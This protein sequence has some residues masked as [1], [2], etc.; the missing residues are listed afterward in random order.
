MRRGI[1]V[2]GFMGCFI[3]LTLFAGMP[4][5]EAQKLVPQVKLILDRLP[6]EKQKRLVDFESAVSTYLA[7]ADWTGDMSWELPLNL[8]VYLQDVSASFEDRY[9]GMCLISNMS[10]L[11]F[12]DK[13]WK[14]PYMAGDRIIYDVNLYE[15]FTG[16]INFYVYLILAGEYDKYSPLGG[17]PC[18]EKAKTIHDQ[19]RFNSTF[20][21]GWDERGKLLQSLMGMDAQPFRRSKYCF[22]AAFDAASR[23]D[24]T[25]LQLGLEGLALLE[26]VRKKDPEHKETRDFLNAHHVNIAELFRNDPDALD[27]LAAADSTHAELY[28]RM[29][30]KRN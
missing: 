2:R 21:Y 30:E 3:L 8:Q 5:L 28:N 15:P 12:Y 14:F 22:F 17:T 13:Y 18:Y 24:T 23:A 26:G 25:A 1:T 9:S 4:R 6:L 19:A 7:D 10:D 11:Q 27:R 20:I 16:V 29:R